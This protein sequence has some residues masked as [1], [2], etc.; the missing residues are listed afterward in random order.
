MNIS[1]LSGKG[2]TGKTTIST[3]LAVR[4][5]TKGYKTQYL[6][7]DVE[8]PN[9]FIFLKPQIKNRE[10]VAVKVPQIDEDL[11]N[12]CGLCAK[13]C[14]F[15]AIS[16]VKGK[17]V[18][19]EK[20]CHSCGLCSIICP[21]K[22]VTETDRVIGK[23]EKGFNGKLITYRGILNIG[24][25]MG[26]PI[27]EKLQEQTK[28]DYINIIDSPPGSSCNVVHSIEGSDYSILVTEPTKFGLHDLKIA[29]KVVE[30]FNI[31]YGVVINKSQQDNIIE[32]FCN[33]NNIKI[34]AKIPFDRKIAHKYSK[35]DL[36][37]N[38]EKIASIFDSIISEVVEVD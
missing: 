2:G 9:G 14:N 13:K 4:L 34:I 28:S 10:D 27:I 11:C 5:T 15:N 22:A 16:V 35:G 12:G 1:V 24:E 31:P 17:V 23:I 26:V 25:P 32:D 37:I 33:K 30:K 29:V 3:N 18:L 6:D 19:F 8:E 20:L 21:Q 7:F 38:D 36:L